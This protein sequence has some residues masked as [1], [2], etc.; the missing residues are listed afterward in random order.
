[1]SNASAIARFLI[2]EHKPTLA[3]RL[4]SMTDDDVGMS[5]VAAVSERF[6]Y[7][8]PDDFMQGLLLAQEIE[9]ADLGYERRGLA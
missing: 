7:C 9:R 1:M 3:G 4:A 5:I 6:P 8:D 2:E